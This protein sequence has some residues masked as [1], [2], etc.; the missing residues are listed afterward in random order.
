[1]SHHAELSHL[2]AAAYGVDVR[3]IIRRRTVLGIVAED[4]AQYIWK[5]L[6]LRDD[7]QRLAALADMQAVFD[8]AKTQAAL[9]L[10]A[11]NGRFVVRNGAG[12]DAG[13]LQPWLTGRHVN[14]TNRPERLAVLRSLARVQRASQEASFPGSDVLQRGTLLQKL[15]LKERAIMRVWPTVEAAYPA[16]AG[17]KAPFWRRMQTIQQRYAASLAEQRQ[18]PTAHIAFCHRDLAPHNVLFRSDGEV[19]WIDFDHAG[20]DDM[21]HDAMQFISHSMFL[22]RLTSSDYHEL[23]Q[24]YVD[25]ARLGR[26][27]TEMLWTLT[28]WPDILIRTLVE[29]YRLNCKPEGRTRVKYAIACELRKQEFHRQVGANSKRLDA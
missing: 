29:W 19:A 5:P 15:R 13:Y 26:D 21:L 2:L 9:P 27:R 20:Y 16:L 17:F 1:M 7:G 14:V 11:K 18:A 6:S 12:A 24:T 22:A 8:G 28:G 3:A 4:G 23:L 25:E 10:P